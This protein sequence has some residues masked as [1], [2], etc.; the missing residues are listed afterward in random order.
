MKNYQQLAARTLIDAPDFEISDQDIMLAW[1]A[2]G[3]AGEAGEVADLVKKDVF[4]RHGLDVGKIK[5]E[6]GDCLWYIA[7]LCSRLDLDLNE[8]MADNIAKL[9]ARYPGGFSTR[10]SINRVDVTPF[11]L[12]NLR[13]FVGASEPASEPG[14]L[15]TRRLSQPPYSLTTSEIRKV[16]EVVETTCNE[17]WDSDSDCNCCN[18]E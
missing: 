2:L 14:T 1:N 5:K 8:V 10:D 12:T 18:D 4:H 9:E 6:L 17:C 11:P 16:I 3:L 13:R 7:A 15:F